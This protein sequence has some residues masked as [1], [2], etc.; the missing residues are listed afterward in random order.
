MISA[1]M[2]PVICGTHGYYSLGGDSR[3]RPNELAVTG[4]DDQLVAKAIVARRATFV[5]VVDESVLHQIARD[6]EHLA[7]LRAAQSCP[8]S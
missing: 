5:A 3:Q 6:A 7:L 4:G 8:T 1:M 2:S